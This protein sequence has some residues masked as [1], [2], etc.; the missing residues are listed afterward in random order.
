MFKHYFKTSWRNIIKDKGYSTFNILGLSIGMA[1]ALMI[2][3]WVQYQ[4]SYDRFLPHYQQAYRTMVSYSRNG[5]GGA[6]D[7]TCL[8]LADALKKNVAEIKYVAQA[9]Y[10][11]QHSLVTGDKKVYSKGIFAGGDFLKI[12]QYPLLQGSAD[13]VLKE[14]AS[15]VLTRATAIAL[16]GHEDPVGRILR[17]DNLHD[18]K[19]SGVL[20]DLPGN[21][22]LQ[23]NYVLPF[24]YYIQTQD[25][26]RGNLSNWNLNPIQ[27]FVALQPNVSM[28][29]TEPALR[30]IMKKYNP[31]GYRV[32]KLEVFL[33]PLKDWH[34]YSDFKN[35]VPSG[36]FIDYV[37]MFGIIGMLVLLIAC[38]NFTNL[39]IVRS[40]KAGP[41]SRSRGERRS[42]RCGG[43]SS[44]NF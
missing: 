24:S 4:F 35:G 5:A 19:V 2:G 7:A 40:G 32:L 11:G 6:G 30:T 17:L 22:S 16:F 42:V 33:H 20:A 37:R 23:F 1:V 36:G 44:F 26:I 43:I 29:Q 15:V 3:L 13:E 10:I 21:S 14:P 34:L 18:V 28:A 25:W 41:G 39:S 9:D 27:T 31:D 12:F 8:P 38:I